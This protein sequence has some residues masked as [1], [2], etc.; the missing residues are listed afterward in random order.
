MTQLSIGS[1]FSG[2]EENPE[3]YLQLI[4]DAGFTHVL[5]SHNWCTNY[6]Y[7]KN[8]IKQIGNWLNNAGLKLLDI[9]ASDGGEKNLGSADESFRKAGVEF[10]T[11]RLKMAAELNG[12]SVMIHLPR[13]GYTDPLRK[14]LDDIQ[15]VSHITGIKLAFENTVWP[16][17]YNASFDIM[18][19]IF[20]DYSSDYFGICYDSGH[21]NLFKNK[22]IPYDYLNHFKDKLI[23]LHL[24][25]N[26]GNGDGHWLP[27]T[28]NIDWERSIKFIS[29]SSY[30]GPINL[31]TS[32][33]IGQQTVKNLLNGGYAAGVKLSDMLKR[34]EQ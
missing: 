10:I 11:N 23:S 15:K 20:Q 5:W 28:G 8:E 2:T 14:S 18:K 16:E 33:N 29:E 31:E 9:H 32:L 3:H 7:T 4:A 25:D 27:F 21:E 26:D 17:C 22:Q 19:E 13:N 6:V 1:T 34:L 12:S 24:H 30:N